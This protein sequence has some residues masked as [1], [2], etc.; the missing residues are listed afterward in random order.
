MLKNK[1]I[2]IG[3]FVILL[4]ILIAVFFIW[5]NNSIN[6]QNIVGNDRDT[7][8][9]IGSAGYSWCEVKNK[10]LRT[11][12]EKCELIKSPLN[13]TYNIDGKNITLEGGKAT[14]TIDGV[15]TKIKT[16]IFGTPNNSDVNGDGVKDYTMLITSDNGSSGTFFYIVVALVD[17]NSE[18]IT[19]TN[20]I[21]LGDRIAPQ[22]IEVKDNK[23]IVNYADRKISE[24]MT[25][26][27]SWGVSKY[28]EISG[29]VLEE[30]KNNIKSTSTTII[31]ENYKTQCDKRNG[32]WYEKTKVCE[33]NQLSKDECIKQN[34]EF[35]ECNSACRNDPDAQICTMQCVVTCSFK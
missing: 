11:W 18:G 16:M 30:I 26:K 9:C 33:A 24:P 7:H 10:C 21:F 19:T 22:N 23:I 13:A 28:F 15:E 6:K 20:S 17:K 31:N 5:K 25:T 14:T 3:I 29:N 4:I 27:P 1:R 35:N 34:G 12:E 32:V 2:I 8:G